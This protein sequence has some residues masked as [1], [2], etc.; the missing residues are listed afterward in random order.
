MTS[1][2]A[3]HTPGRE[4]S[5]A[6]PSLQ[7]AERILLVV[8]FV[9]LVAY[10]SA[11]ANRSL[12]QAEQSQ[13]FDGALERAIA[14]ETHDQTEWAEGRIEAY[15]A[16]RGA[17]VEALGRLTIPDAG[18]SVMVLE[19]TDEATL[20]RAVGRIEG[21]ADLD[22]PGNVGIAGHR[23]GFFRGLRHLEQGDEMS[24]ASQKGLTRYRVSAISIVE[25]EDVEVLDPSPLPVLTLVT[26]YPFYYVG[27]APQ[28]FI[29][30]ADQVSF[31]PWTRETARTYLES[32]D[33][34]R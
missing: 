34:T 7:V 8:A 20:D 2:Q 33:T 23:D 27:S 11:C 30:R 5:R 21:T 1:T 28:R 22:E 25:P 24:V 10:V 18:V 31:E 19:G 3:G 14:A 32:A 4:R 26:C 29:V 12:F 6:A 15:S 17:E 16:S 9:C 13:H